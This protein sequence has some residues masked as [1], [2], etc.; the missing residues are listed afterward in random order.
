M[1]RDRYGDV[2]D[3]DATSGTTGHEVHPTDCRDGWLTDAPD[4]TPRPCVLCK[5]W[6]AGTHRPKATP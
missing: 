3:D 5:P 1:R 6:L 2:I 4:G